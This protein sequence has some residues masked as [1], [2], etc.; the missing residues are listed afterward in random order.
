VAGLPPHELTG[1]RRSI[2][3]ALKAHAEKETS[4]GPYCDRS[5]FEGITGLRPNERGPDPRGAAGGDSLA[6]QIPG[7]ATAEPGGAGGL[8]G[9]VS[10]RGCGAGGGSR[11]GGRAGVAGTVAGSGRS[12]RQDRYAG[13]AEPERGVLP[14]EQAAGG[15]HPGESF[16]RSEGDVRN[17][18]R[19]DSG[20]DETHQHRSRLDSTT[21]ARRGEKRIT[22]DVPAACE[23]TRHGARCDDPALR[24]TGTHGDP[25]AVGSDP[26]GGRGGEGGRGHGSNVSV[27]DDSA[28]GRSD[29]G[30]TVCGGDRRREAILDGAQAAGI[31]RSDARGEFELS[32]KTPYGAD[33]GR[34]QQ[35]QMGTGTSGVGGASLLQGPSGGGVVSGSRKA[36]RQTGGRLGAGPSA[37]RGVVRDVAGREAV[38]Q[39]PPPPRYPRRERSRLIDSQGA[40]VCVPPREAFHL[41]LPAPPQ[42]SHSGTPSFSEAER[43]DWHKLSRDGDRDRRR[44]ARSTLSRSVTSSPR[45]RPVDGLQPLPPTSANSRVRQRVPDLLEQPPPVTPPAARSRAARKDLLLTGQPLHSRLR[46]GAA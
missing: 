39:E 35:A 17:T 24:R 11:D 2:R 4:H 22:N 37:G 15:T 40:R 34:A 38:R 9:G 27:V 41:H 30:R 6:R 28:G 23:G 25:G 29:D 8:R 21:R 3:D 45:V 42:A 31:P 14:H 32:A 5:R 16:P 46:R 20:A 44:E 10:G 33:Q 12:R 13:C 19:V 43:E 36:A 7:R 26:G 1:Y 18:R